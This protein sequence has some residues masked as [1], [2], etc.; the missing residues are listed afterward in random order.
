VEKKE[1]TGE[2]K[3]MLLTKIQRLKIKNFGHK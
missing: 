1:E 2:E 3:K